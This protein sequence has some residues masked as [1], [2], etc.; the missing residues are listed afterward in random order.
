MKINE[1]ITERL[2]LAGDPLG[3]IKKKPATPTDQQLA[4]FIGQNA[5]NY[6]HNA[7]KKA[8][9]M[10]KA[11]ATRDAIWAATRT[12]RDVNGDL[13]QEIPDD[14][15]DFKM[16]PTSIKGGSS[17]KASDIFNHKEFFNNYPQFKNATITFVD[18]KNSLVAGAGGLY[19]QHNNTLYITKQPTVKGYEMQEWEEYLDVAIHELDHVAQSIEKPNN[20]LFRNPGDH[21]KAFGQNDYEQYA[22][23]SRE[24]YSRLAA[25]RRELDAQQRAAGP[26]PTPT[27]NAT[28]TTQ[29]RTGGINYNYGTGMGQNFSTD[30]YD[31][32]PA[33]RA[34]SIQ[35]ILNPLVTSDNPFYYD[36]NAD[37]MQDP[38]NAKVRGTVLKNKPD[39][40][41]LSELPPNWLKTKPET[42]PVVNKQVVKKP[43][44]KKPVVK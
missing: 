4:I 32:G 30:T 6:D 27:D 10:E 18:P 5:K 12:F 23:D 24:T 1:I 34:D 11:G 29:K 38:S 33:K 20:H 22:A 7:Q 37:P 35:N 28:I 19:D 43:V 39:D 3:K 8:L 31:Q 44:V 26:V 40:G 21:T 2:P 16:D 17:Y 41:P 42:P 25:A 15:F 36:A 9:E 14:Q 13:R